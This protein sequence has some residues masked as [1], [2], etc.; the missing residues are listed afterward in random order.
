MNGQ[1]LTEEYDSRWKHSF[2]TAISRYKCEGMGQQTK[3]EILQGFG[4]ER[5][6]QLAG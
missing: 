5:K 2:L 1:I 4:G 3:M 6:P